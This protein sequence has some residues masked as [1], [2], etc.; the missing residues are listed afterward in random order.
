MSLRLT[1][2]YGDIMVIKLRR[3]SLAENVTRVKR[4][5]KFIQIYSRKL[6]GRGHFR[7]TGIDGKIIFKS[8][9]Q[10]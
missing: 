7:D 10:D 8:V 4:C 2:A 5:E 9:L 1:R 6:D 3:M